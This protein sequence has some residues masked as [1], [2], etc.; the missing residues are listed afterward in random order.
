MTYHTNKKVVS[1]RPTGQ[2]MYNNLFNFIEAPNND[3]V[4]GLNAATY[5]TE[6][7]E[8]L[9]SIYGRVGGVV[10]DSFMGTGTTAVAAKKMG[11]KYIGSEISEKQCKYAEHRLRDIKTQMSLF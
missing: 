11:M 7:C 4:N 1:V 9:L 10:Y 6:L 2:K 8:K 5:S 3:G